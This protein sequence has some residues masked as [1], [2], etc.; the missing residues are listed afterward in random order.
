M[1]LVPSWRCLQIRPRSS[2]MVNWYWAVLKWKKKKFHAPL[3]QT[4]VDYQKKI[5]NSVVLAAKLV[6][7][8]RRSLA[9]T[10]EKWDGA[11]WIFFGQRCAAATQELLFIHYIKWYPIHIFCSRFCILKYRAFHIFF[12][13]KSNPFGSH[14]YR[15]SPTSL[16][17]PCATLHVSKARTKNLIFSG[18]A[19]ACIVYMCPWF[20]LDHFV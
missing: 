5:L 1:N 19:H 14:V 7:F 15:K 11:T 17:G 3:I 2:E 20:W 18:S 6:K 10:G 13:C 16:L 4:I 8:A 12:H 9:I